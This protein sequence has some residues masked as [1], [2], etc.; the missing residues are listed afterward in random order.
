VIS[1]PSRLPFSFVESPFHRNVRRLRVGLKNIAIGSQSQ[2]WIRNSEYVRKV[3][4][5]FIP[6]F[7]IL[8]GYGCESEK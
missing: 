2:T 4:V 8:F 6:F 3:Y 1:L 5:E 7:C